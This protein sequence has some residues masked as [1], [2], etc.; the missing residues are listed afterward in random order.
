[1]AEIL[2]RARRG[3]ISEIRRVHLVIGRDLDEDSVR[4]YFEQFATHE[5]FRECKLEISSGEGTG[6][7]IQEIEGSE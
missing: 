6:I 7:L 4:F 2:E 5:R 3:G 1:V